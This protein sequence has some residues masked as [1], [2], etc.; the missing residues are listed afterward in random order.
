MARHLVSSGEQKE[1]ARK[2][3]PDLKQQALSNICN[4]NRM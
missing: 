4:N 3:L 1:N 2:A